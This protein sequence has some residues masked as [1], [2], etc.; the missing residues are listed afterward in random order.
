MAET[1]WNPEWAVAPGEVLVE[2]LEERAMTQAELGRRMA[3]P[4]KTINEIASGK[5]AITP[6]TAIQLERAIGIAAA[7]WLRLESQ[8]REAQ[9]RARDAAELESHVDWLRRFPVTSLIQRGVLDRGASPSQQAATLLRFF[10]VSNP[11]GWTQHWGRIAAEY[12]MSERLAVSDEA[13]A[14]WLRLAESRVTDELPAFDEKRLRANLSSLRE[15]SRA[16]VVAGAIVQARELL[17]QA[18]VGFLLTD[19]VQGAPASGALRWIRRNPW[20]MLTARHGT[21]DQF[22]FSLFHEIGHILEQGRRRGVLEAMSDRESGEPSEQ[23]ANAFARDFLIP[24]SDFDLWLQAGTI[25]RPSIKQFAAQVRVSPGIV[26]GRL[27]RDGHA[28]WAMFNDL[29]RPVRP[30]SREAAP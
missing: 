7:V 9:A 5:A 4:L 6:E 8:Y 21:D 19:G 23:A 12:R 27:Q 26:V 25:N 11:A 20:V 10:G 13:V 17:R 30:V 18:G 2:A 24:Q 22:W 3:R 29:K 15:L 28:S 1:R 16:H 14:V